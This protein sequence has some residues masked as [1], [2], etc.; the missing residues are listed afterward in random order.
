MKNDRLSYF[1]NLLHIESIHAGGF[2]ADEE[3][4]FHSD[5]RICVYSKKLL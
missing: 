1:W 2:I 5:Q 4:T 3:A